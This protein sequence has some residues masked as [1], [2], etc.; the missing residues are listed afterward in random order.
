VLRTAVAF[1][2]AGKP[3]RSAL[4][5]GEVLGN[6]ELSRRDAAFFG[7]RRAAALALSGEPDEAATVGLKSVE[8]ATV[9]SSRRTLRVLGETMDTLV[10]W[11]RRPLVRELQDA[12]AESGQ[13]L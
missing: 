10:P 9:T 5:F 11:R 13:C 3:A 8:V 7:A 6:S 4:M 1:T 12:M 2:E